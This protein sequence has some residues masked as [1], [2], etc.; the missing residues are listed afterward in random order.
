M[1]ESDWTCSAT[2]RFTPARRK[3]MIEGEKMWL[4]STLTVWRRV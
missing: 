3:F 1:A 2:T 4:S